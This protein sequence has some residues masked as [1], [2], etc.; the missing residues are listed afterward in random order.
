M[1][2]SDATLNGNAIMSNTA[3][4]GGGL[5]TYFG[6]PTVSENTIAG[7][8]A[9]WYGGGVKLATG[10][11]VNGNTVFSR[12]LIGH[13]TAYDG[14]GMHLLTSYG[15][16]SNTI[17]S[18]NI[19]L[20]NTASHDGGGV[21]LEQSDVT[22]NGNTISSNT[23]QQRGGGLYLDRS[24]AT[25][26]GNTISGNTA[27]SGGG[28]YLYRHTDTMLN[29]NFV[30]GNTA[31]GIGGGLVVD[32]A[33]VWVIGPTIA[34]NVISGNT[35][36]IGG[37]VSVGLCA[38]MFTNNLVVDNE[39]TNRGSGLYFYGTKPLLLHTTIARNSGGEGSG[40][41][42][43][44]SGT[45][46]T[47]YLTNTIIV[48]QAIGVYADNPFIVTPGDVIK[49][50]GT[51]WGSGIGA[52]NL[53]WGGEGTILTGT[54]NIWGD[55]AFVDPD[56]GDYHIGPG[57][58]AI[59]TG[60][61]A[62]VT[63][64]IDGESRPVGEGYDIGADERFSGPRLMVT[65]QANANAVQP[66]EW[67]TYT[68]HVTNTGTVSLTATITDFLPSG[69]DPT[70]ALS[71]QHTLTDP[72]DVWTQTVV[73]TVDLGYTGP[74]TNAVQVT[75]EEGATG[76]YTNVVTVEEAIA[77]LTAINDS[78]TT[79]GDTTRLTATITAGSNVT[80]AWAF[81]D[82]QSGVGAEADYVYPAAGVYTAVITASNNINQLVATTTV[83]I[84]ESPIVGLVATNDSPTTLDDTT[85]LTATITS[86]SNVT[87]TWAFGDG[88]SSV[89]AEVDHVYPAVGIYTAVVTASNAVSELT[90]TTTVTI[91]DVSIAGL[92]ATNDSPTELD[93][94][95][96]LTATVSTGTNVT[97]SW[98]FGDGQSSVGAE[99]DHVYPAVGV[100]TA[101]VT[102]SNNINHL[103]ATTTVTITQPGFFVYLPLVVKN[104]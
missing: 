10:E 28:I 19:I 82:G 47:V 46:S 27:S 31:Q 41:Y 24:P 97:Y 100:Y 69:V 83:T 37:G 73:I 17:L 56:A 43:T 89:G 104:H 70:G 42:A 7:N 1:Y 71:W 4:Q 23:A 102:A 63:V 3:Q 61:D 85:R 94:T 79:L 65:K 92:I 80:Y 86:G 58:A 22:L 64:D 15:Q 2:I 16:N 20:S 84:T 77:G 99:V 90:A 62:G 57:S 54:V 13:N 76:I 67:L 81:G 6:S 66:G 9:Q 78:P 98:A 45:Y 8:T 74:L 40:I 35:A 18:K 11:N 53:D 75:T 60:V 91:T 49:M 103:V 48:S 95:T 72:G 88:E 96:Q 87:Y 44:G 36:D 39:A 32:N 33:Y 30:I 68:L 50:E 93:G 12:N 101:V 51:L 55:P 21:Y 59:D 34:S 5:Y 38:P 14:G 29:G 25:L 26:N 52:N